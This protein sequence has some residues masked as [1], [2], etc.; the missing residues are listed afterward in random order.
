MAR[1][2]MADLVAY[3]PI[4]ND[5]PVLVGDKLARYTSPLSVSKGRLCIMVKNDAM[6][7]RLQLQKQSIISQINQHL[8]S[9]KVTD[10][11]FDFSDKG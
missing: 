5:W 9:E 7:H 3:A 6:R 4:W 10:L 8:D 2:S 11:I 1:S